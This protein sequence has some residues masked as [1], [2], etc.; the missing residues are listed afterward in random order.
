MKV[1]FCGAAKIVT[2]SNY[3]IEVG[4]ERI[5]IDCGM[6][7]GN[8]H[9]TRLNYRP[10]RFDPKHISHVLL[11][12]AHIDHSGL[13][14]KLVKERFKG[15]ILATE[16]TIDLCR[17]MLED[18]AHI[19]EMDTQHENERLKVR[20]QPL[21]QPLYT[22]DDVASTMPLFQKIVYNQEIQVTKHIKA[23]YRDGGHII[24]SAIIELIVDD[25]GEEKRLV[26]S[27]DLG[28]WDVPIIEDPTIIEKADY[29]FLEST[30][31]NRLHE[32]VKD[33]DVKLLEYAERAFSRGG[34]VLIPSFAIER[35]QELLYSF[36]KLIKRGKFPDMKIFL[37]SP[38]AIKATEIFKKHPEYFDEEALKKYRNPF[39]FPNLVYTRT[40]AE[41][42]AINDYDKPCVVIAG[43]GMCTAGRIRHHFK[44]GL[45]NPKNIV[46]FVG[47]QARGT[48]G[49]WILEGQKR[50]RFMGL[51]VDVKADIEK[52]NSF[53]AHADYRDI[54]RWVNGF[55]QKPKKIFLVHGEQRSAIELKNKLGKY[56]CV[57]PSIGDIA[58]L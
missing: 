7:Q 32:D 37:D 47:Y 19:Q 10:F 3:L 53:S 6:F 12:H 40:T 20:G 2:G 39:N 4:G 17:I 34:R 25:N 13:I 42:K 41:S 58:K 5:L 55:K 54:L 23:I 57:I 38:L 43:S 1:K 31:G 28:Q 11:T 16:A 35:T 49:R 50:V 24:G 15:K 48:L 14:P 29:L 9:I 18:S 46:V 22:Q 56:Q 44:Y 8:K 30:Y 21:R 33:R 36:N 51:Y 52:I 45:D 26:F 27:G